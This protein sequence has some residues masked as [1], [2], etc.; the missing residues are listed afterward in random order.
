MSKKINETAAAGSIGAHSVAVR[1][2]RMGAMQTRMSLKDFMLKFHSGLTNRYKFHAVNMEGSIKSITE[3]SKFP[4]QVDDAV[5]RLKGMEMT[6][7]RTD[8]DIVTYGIEDDDG[9]MMKITVPLEQGEDF[10]RQVA[11][12][13]ADVLDYK[14]TGKGEDKSL[15]ELLYE[16]KDQF[17]IISAEFPIVPKDAVYNADEVTEGLPDEDDLDD[18]DDIDALDGEE[19]LDGEEEFDPEDEELGDEFEGGDSKEDLLTSVLGMLKSQNEKEVAQANAEAEKARAKQAELALQASTHEMQTAEDAIASQ[20]EMEAEK[21]KEKRAKDMADIAKFNYRKRMGE[22]VGFSL[23]FRE[24]LLELDAN[25]TVQSLRRQMSTIP[26]RYQDSPGDDDATKSFNRQQQQAAM[27]E[28]RIKMRAA[29][30]RENFEREQREKEEEVR[31]RQE[32]VNPQ[33][34]QNN[35]IRTNDRGQQQ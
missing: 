7:D 15:A 14:K 23:M 18:V 11:Q 25:D 26:L 16:L 13:L 28:L 27:R 32:P 24:T 21:D 22:D 35:Q 4:Y 6:S 1:H 8:K 20:A 30:N 2:D 34:P 12:A 5:S 10:E 31:Q 19:K 33:D 3:S 29:R 9:V 17:T